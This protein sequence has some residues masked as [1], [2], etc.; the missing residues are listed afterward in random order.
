MVYVLFMKKG[1]ISNGV[2]TLATACWEKEF[3]RAQAARSRG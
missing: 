1:E 3:D 2:A